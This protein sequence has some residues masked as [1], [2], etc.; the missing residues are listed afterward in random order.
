M[1][2]EGKGL[3]EV[4]QPGALQVSPSNGWATVDWLV[5]RLAACLAL[6]RPV[7]MTEEAAAEWLA[8]A[9]TEL[10]GYARYTVEDALADA[11]RNC[12]HHG[13]IIPH[14]VRHMEASE[15]WRLGKPL[16]RRLPPAPEPVS[17]PRLEA[18]ISQTADRMLLA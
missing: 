17:N 12:T 5:P 7:S 10:D 1:D 4:A 15:P 13:Q 16:P 2:E 18:L 9:A 11:R 8:V 6:V 14:A 3:I